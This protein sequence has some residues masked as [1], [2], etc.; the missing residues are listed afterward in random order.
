M[1]VSKICRDGGATAYP[2]RYEP[3]NSLKKNAHISPNWTPEELEMI[4]DARRVL[5]S[6]VAF[7]PYKGFRKKI[8][9]AKSFE[10]AF[11]LRPPKKHRV[12]N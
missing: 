8:L 12:K 10:E 4:A 2:M 7:P 1:N 5:G 6:R 3:L 11:K 9:G